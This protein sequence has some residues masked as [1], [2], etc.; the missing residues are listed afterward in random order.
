MIENTTGL[1]DYEVLSKHCHVCETV[2]PKIQDDEKND[3]NNY[4]SWLLTHHTVTKTMTVL[5]E[6][7]ICAVKMWE[8]SKQH[9][10]RYKTVM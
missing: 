6:A 1:V 10:F 8:R 5:L 3:K 4:D 9:G 7:Q 2:G